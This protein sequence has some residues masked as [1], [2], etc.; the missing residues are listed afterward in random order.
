M[1]VLCKALLYSVLQQSA[2]IYTARARFKAF[3][4]CLALKMEPK[5]GPETSVT[6]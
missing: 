6:V 3:W 2:H 4:D 5:G 1:D